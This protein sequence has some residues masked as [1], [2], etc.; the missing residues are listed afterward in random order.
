MPDAGERRRLLGCHQ[1]DGFV[2]L[3]LQQMMMLGRSKLE[4]MLVAFVLYHMV[5][6]LLIVVSDRSEVDT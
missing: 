6:W 5:V 1:Q 3:K 2:Y 4:S